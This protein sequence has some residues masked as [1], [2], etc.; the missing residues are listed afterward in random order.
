[1]TKA[2]RGVRRRVGVFSLRCSCSQ[3]PSLVAP[4]VVRLAGCESGRERWT[5]HKSD[6]AAQ[7]PQHAR[8]TRSPR[9]LACPG[10]GLRR[11]ATDNGGDAEALHFM[12]DGSFRSRCHR[13]CRG[14]ARLV[15]ARDRGGLHAC[16]R[17]DRDRQPFSRQR[18]VIPS[19][20]RAGGRDLARPGMRGRNVQFD[21]LSYTCDGIA[22]PPSYSAGTFPHRPGSGTN[23][24]A[25]S[26]R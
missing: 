20:D 15:V 24:F 7:P 26:R 16:R 23:R 13:V 18:W 3:H 11:S 9:D 4:P 12:V 1:M 10:I 2:D 22:P 6:S 8:N 21:W 25:G 14:L 17:R 5:P 19:A